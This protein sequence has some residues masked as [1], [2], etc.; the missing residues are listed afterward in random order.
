MPVVGAVTRLLGVCVL[1]FAASIVSSPSAAA[2]RSILWDSVDIEAQLDALGTLHVEGTH[3]IRFQG[4]W[5]G[6]ERS[7]RL[8]GP[9]QLTF[10]AAGR[11]GP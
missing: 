9:Q 10:R 7:F 2:E 1:L 4:D 6:G 8:V 3:S 5:N 11:R